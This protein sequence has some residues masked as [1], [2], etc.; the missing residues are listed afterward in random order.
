MS[1]V[2]DENNDL[3]LSLGDLGNI[4]K[5]AIGRSFYGNDL[6]ANMKADNLKIYGRILSDEEIKEN[7][8]YV[9]KHYSLDIDASK[10]GA[11]IT[12]GTV[13]LFFED[14]STA[15]DGGIYSEQINNRS[16]EALDAKGNKDNPA[17]DPDFAWK[18][19]GG[20]T[21]AYNTDEPLNNNN[22]T[23]LTLTAEA[24]DSGVENNCYSGDGTG[25]NP[26]SKGMN[27]VA[28][29]KYN[30]SLFV[31]G[32]YDGEIKMQVVNG[33]SV[34]GETAF[35]GV[36]GEFTKKSGVITVAEDCDDA[37]VRVVLS[38]PGTVDLDMISLIPQQTFN[39]R[40]NGLRA[41]LVERL[42]QLHPG[43]LRFPGGCIIEGYNLANRY[44]WKQTVGPEEQRVLNW[45]R[46]QTE[47]TMNYAYCQ[48]FG[49]GFYEYFLLCEDLGAEPVPV[50]NVGLA[51]QYQ[52]REASTKDEFYETYLPDF[53]DLIEFA[54]GTPDNDW[55]TIDYSK[56]DTNNPDTF[57]DN[58]ANLRALMGHPE[59]FD[60]KYIG[61]GNEQ[62]DTSDYTNAGEDGWA[63]NGNN[64]FARYEAIEK[65]VHAD[66]PEMRLIAT[67]GPSA[68]D[69]G[70][71]YVENGGVGAFSKAW[72]WANEKLKEN[73]DF[74]YAI[75][76]H[77]YKQPDW[78]LANANRYDMYDRN[79]AAVFAGEYASRWW[80]E[81]R[82]NTWESALSEAAF[83]NG[84]ERNSDVVK[85]ASFA[86]LFAKEGGYQWSPNMIWF[87]NAKSYGTPDYYVQWLYSRNSGTYN[88][89]SI[90][91][92]SYDD[93]SGKVGVGTWLTS[94]SFS[95]LKVV[96]DD[97]GE[98]I[99][100]NG[101]DD[102]AEGD[103]AKGGD[104]TVE[105]AVASQTNTGAT[106]GTYLFANMEPVNAKNFT[107]T[108]KATKTGGNEGFTIPVMAKDNN[109]LVHWNVGGWGN[110]ASSFEVR[111]NGANGPAGN[112]VGT[113]LKEGQ[114][115]ELKI[116]AK[117]GVLYGF[118]DG[119]L[120]NT[121]QY[122][123]VDP[124]YTNAIYDEETGDVIVKLVNYTPYPAN[125]PVTVNNADLTGRATQYLMTGGF[126]DK[127][128]I[129]EP[130]KVAP[131]RSEVD[132]ASGEEYVMPAYSFAVLR[133][134]T[135][136]SANAVAVESVESVEVS[137]KLGEKPV[138][139]ED[140]A[141]TLDGG[142]ADRR[143]V[144]WVLPEIGTFANAGE[145]TV[146]GRVEGTELDAVAKVTVTED[147]LPV[148][149]ADIDAILNGTDSVIAFNPKTAD[150][151]LGVFAVYG[152]NGMESVQTVKF[153]G[154]NGRM[155]VKGLD[156]D[157]KSA[158]IMLWTYDGLAPA[159]DSV[160]ITPAN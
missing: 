47:G 56:V 48:T 60:M 158:R 103:F 43:F 32:D 16:F 33:E 19:V 58:W 22:K 36:T 96:N 146:Y 143:Q 45:N 46:W 110:T 14:L 34:I 138:L 93:Y 153:T 86:P 39:G 119:E 135:E 159:A 5:A 139:P 85:M 29:A 99:T 82:G 37:R 107:V 69:A 62:V 35:D 76:E 145:F 21:A 124:V 27:A 28:G 17:K 114:E 83:M 40:D 53:L 128:S 25:D 44:Q 20:A 55:N 117:N 111:T 132:F 155:T 129:D 81:L 7:A 113:E 121:Y 10:R 118:I 9:V 101:W 12:P 94:A 109:N 61:V 130:E 31:R 133:I 104:W 24:E 89:S 54:N 51:C 73:P 68:D 115:Y 87:D 160:E 148:I 152:P 74:T 75:D 2:V 30:A 157:G 112:Y 142:A 123:P 3:T 134:H 72:N 65:A 136:N 71:Q 91:N 120:I 147:E 105:G 98:E 126:L 57:N 18:T 41:D 144:T 125:I 137:A 77:Y 141:V 49:L 97:T 88:V 92:D 67:S 78:I 156:L 140:V 151:Y 154:A 38:K 149:D 26:K 64:F 122:D 150:T 80:S 59:S 8:E 84:F 108:L 127:N 6:F 79:G 95:D 42:A 90:L 15:A 131:E 11:D 1:T 4:A 50:L 63:D 70:D 102:T 106:G 66:Y 23:Y 13:G 52:S 100:V 116:V